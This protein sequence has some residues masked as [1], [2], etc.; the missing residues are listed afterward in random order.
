[1]KLLGINFSRVVEKVESSS[2]GVVKAWADLTDNWYKPNWWQL[3]QDKPDATTALRSS[4]VYT[5]VSIL[6][7]EIARLN[8]F[9]YTN[10]DLKGQIEMYKSSYARLLRKPNKYQTRSDF[11]LSLM[12]SL[13]MN[14]N[15]YAMATRDTRGQIINFTPLN[16]SAVQPY[17]TPEGEIYYSLFNVEITPESD[18][19]V[20]KFIPQRSMLHIRLFTPTHPLI[21]VTPL[22]ACMTSVAHGLSIQSEATRFF[23]NGSKPAGIL[24]TPKPL[25]EVQATRLRDAWA[26]G[27]SGINTGKVPVLDN[28]LQ[29]QQMS[30]SATDAQLIEQYAMT[31]KDIAMV[32]RIPMYMI[33]EGDSQFKTAEA[34]QRDFV[35]RALG[36]YIEHIEASLEDFFEFDGRTKSIEFDV[37][38]GI[39]R[40]EYNAR[41]EGLAKEVQGGISTPNE[42]RSSEG[43]IAKEG[44][45]DLFM[46]RQMVPLN[47]LGLDVLAMDSG[48]S[49]DDNGSDTN[50][51]EP[52]D[53]D[54]QV[55]MAM[56]F[57]KLEDNLDERTANSR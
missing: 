45:D 10:P 9:H 12:Y 39:M 48:A 25:T 13:L 18:F 35:T 24:R 11:F 47:L 54:K 44:G 6:A 52:E 27:T 2:T 33:G 53:E 3:G 51:D 21:G 42:A 30:L 15:F 26:S 16:P 19:D 36:F 14:G 5:C 57:N 8:V 37:E 34:S 49:N 4:A 50:S 38:G 41:I 20:S 29:F 55:D 7:Q 56:M 1:M 43:K 46:Q 40:P 22:I 23:D 32:Y 17:V 28:D 31:K